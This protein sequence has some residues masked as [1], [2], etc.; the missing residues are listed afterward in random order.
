MYCYQPSH[1]WLMMMTRNCCH[2]VSE[3]QRYLPVK[4]A[5]S[6]I[7]S[8]RGYDDLN[9]TKL[10]IWIRIA[11]AIASQAYR[12]GKSEHVAWLWRIAFLNVFKFGGTWK[13]DIVKR[14]RQGVWFAFSEIITLRS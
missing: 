9:C 12:H 14:A 11:V 13:D 4:K 2:L 7:L 10:A 6:L 8:L 5:F 3:C 1:K